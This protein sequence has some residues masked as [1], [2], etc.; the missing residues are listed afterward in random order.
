MIYSGEIKLSSTLPLELCNAMLQNIVLALS[1]FLDVAV[2]IRLKALCDIFHC[3]P[4]AKENCC[5]LSSIEPWYLSLPIPE[6]A[7]RL[8]ESAWGSQSTTY[9]V[10]FY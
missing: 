3:V 9:R 8:F 10:H 5:Y 7:I 1:N 4:R 2:H 6:C